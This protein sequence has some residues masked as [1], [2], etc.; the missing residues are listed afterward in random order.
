MQK[1]KLIMFYISAFLA[2]A[3]AVAYQYFVKRVPVSIN[4]LVSVMG[5]YVAVLALSIILLKSQNKRCS[6]KE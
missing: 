5:L 4:P 2:I 1:K 6:P 3:G